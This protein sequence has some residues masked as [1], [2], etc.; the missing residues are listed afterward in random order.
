MRLFLA[1]GSP[2][3]CVFLM[4]SRCV[5]LRLRLFDL[6]GENAWHF[7]GICTTKKEEKLLLHTSK[8][9][10]VVYIFFFVICQGYAHA[11]MQ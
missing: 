4:I 8:F 3:C 1:F 11:H 10:V 6:F 7:S 9:A 5:A 2:N